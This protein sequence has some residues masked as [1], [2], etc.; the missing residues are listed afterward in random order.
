[1]N[2]ETQIGPEVQINYWKCLS[3]YTTDAGY[4]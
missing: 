4:I 2:Q 3:L 1:M